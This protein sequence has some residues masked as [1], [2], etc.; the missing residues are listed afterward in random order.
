MALENHTHQIESVFNYLDQQFMEEKFYGVSYASNKN[1]EFYRCGW[2]HY[3]PNAITDYDWESRTTVLSDCMDWKPNGSGE[4]LPTNCTTWSGSAC[5]QDEGKAFKI[6]WM[7]SIPGKDNELTYNENRLFN[8]W[9]FIAD[10]DK[11]LKIHG[12]GLYSGANAN[13]ETNATPNNE[14][15]I[16]PISETGVTGT[17]EI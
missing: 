9:D 16:I 13:E 11:S 4:K 7:Q 10:F 15:N 1:L 3:P 8:W 14:T 2:T 6:W 5:T 12:K 17:T